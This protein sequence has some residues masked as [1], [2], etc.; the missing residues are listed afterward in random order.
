MKATIEGGRGERGDRMNIDTSGARA[1][2]IEEAIEFHETNDG[3]L[4]GSRI[5]ITRRVRGTDRGG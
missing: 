4:G 5:F 1:M 2:G 3:H